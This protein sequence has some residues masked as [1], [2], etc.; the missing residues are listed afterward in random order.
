[1]QSF[2]NLRKFS[3]RNGIGRT[4]GL[5]ANIPPFLF[6][7]GE[8]LGKTLHDAKQIYSKKEFY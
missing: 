7:K 5:F 6:D 8:I 2:F 4:L 1:M 3:F